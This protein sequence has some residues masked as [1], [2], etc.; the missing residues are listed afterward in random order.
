MRVAD[1]TGS[2]IEPAGSRM[3]PYYLVMHR[4]LGRCWRRGVGY[5]RR[6]EVLAGNGGYERRGLPPITATA[7]ASYPADDQAAEYAF[8]V[9]GYGFRLVGAYDL[10]LVGGL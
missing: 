9:P 3:G 6:R 10:T 2:R 7:P 4:S 5:D 8:P 1:Q